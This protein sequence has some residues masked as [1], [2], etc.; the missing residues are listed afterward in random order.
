VSSSI[1][2]WSLISLITFIVTQAF[3]VHEQ[4]NKNQTQLSTKIKKKYSKMNLSKIFDKK[5]RNTLLV[6][7]AISRQKQVTTFWADV[8]FNGVSKIRIA[9]ADRYG[10]KHNLSLTELQNVCT[11]N[12]INIKETNTLRYFRFVQS[13]EIQRTPCERQLPHRTFRL[14]ET[15]FG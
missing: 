8:N 13:N 9:L 11:S 3:F 5:S 6:N 7:G 15:L 4:S 12:L 14:L 10:E 2:W 1:V